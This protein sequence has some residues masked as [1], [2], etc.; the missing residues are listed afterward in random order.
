MSV[1][2]STRT[3]ELEKLASLQA[4]MRIFISMQCDAQAR[5]YA[6]LHPQATQQVVTAGG[7]AAGVLII[8][9]SDFSIEILEI[10]LLP[11]FRRRGVGSAVVRALID[12]AEALGLPIRC[13]V[14]ADND[15]RA[16]WEQLGFRKGDSDGAYL[17][18]ERPCASSPR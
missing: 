9:R 15:A 6:M 16:F 13:R 7:E 14:A 2:A 17:A 10:A 3:A 4:D 18:M 5:H 8:D 12:E 1:F 11:R